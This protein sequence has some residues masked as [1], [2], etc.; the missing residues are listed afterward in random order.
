[1]PFWAFNP[2]KLPSRTVVSV[3][4]APIIGYIVEMTFSSQINKVT[5]ASVARI[6]ISGH[7]PKAESMTV[8]KAAGMSRP[9]S[10]RVSRLVSMK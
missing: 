3:A 10:G 1:M 4:N 2:P 5:R 8:S 7:Q 6:R 9:V